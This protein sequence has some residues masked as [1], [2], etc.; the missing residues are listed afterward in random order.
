MEKVKVLENGCWDFTS[1]IGK[2]G[3]ARFKLDRRLRLAHRVSYEWH[4]GEIPNGFHL[5]H[6]CER[7][8]CV[9]PKHLEPHSPR[10]HIVFL[11][12]NAPAYK[13]FRKTHCP[14]GHLYTPETTYMSRGRHR[15]C[16]E[17]MKE[18]W[19]R[20]TFDVGGR[21]VPT[22]ADILVM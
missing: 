14:K 19:L 15:G 4:I 3:Y 2:N 6:T 16:R 11:S 5:H 13:R 22:F 1:C 18:I 8:S 21:P 20:H 9:N 12:P 10:E 17:C 7:K